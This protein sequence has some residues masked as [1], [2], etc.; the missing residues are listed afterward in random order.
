MLCLQ[1]FARRFC[2][3]VMLCGATA[4]A[5]QSLV[6]TEAEARSNA[7]DTEYRAT[8]RYVAR[9]PADSELEMTFRNLN[10]GAPKRRKPFSVTVSGKDVSE[11]ISWSEP[12]AVQVDYLALIDVGPP[13]NT[14][15][16]TKTV[17]DVIRQLALSDTKSKGPRWRFRFISG[18]DRECRLTDD[19]PAEALAS[20]PV[21]VL[22][23]EVAKARPGQ[24]PFPEEDMETLLPLF[25][26]KPSHVLVVIAE[27]PPLWFPREATEWLSRDDAAP[28]ERRFRG[29]ETQSHVRI[30]IP[31]AA[32]RLAEWISAGHVVPV[33]TSGRLDVPGETPHVSNLRAG[34]EEVFA[35][36][37]TARLQALLNPKHTLVEYRGILHVPL[38]H[39]QRPPSGVYDVQ[40]ALVANKERVTSREAPIAE[41]A[42]LSWL[43]RQMAFYSRV[44]LG[45]A[46]A[47]LVLLF[48][49]H[50]RRG[51]AH[52]D[53]EFARTA[54]NATFGFAAAAF[55]LATGLVGES[56][57]HYRVSTEAVIVGVA[58]TL[59]AFSL[60]LN[61]YLQAR[62]E[63][64]L[65]LE[66]V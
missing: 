42:S 38:M 51:V 25:E 15:I 20:N 61:R 17:T 36:V 53:S 28:A 44:I 43:P 5:P 27:T 57:L 12:E 31:S 32:A 11:H 41:R 55:G 13:G 64:E 58:L 59:I 46:L 29:F 63:T 22:E 34:T 54:R 9:V 35:R 49:S 37:K 7:D 23:A 56:Y 47:L 45:S 26:G 18:D 52:I 1:R 4:A 19:L 65:T 60:W 48:V 14:P 50:L 6:I 10:L 24:L 33:F 39:A 16:L 30:G 8:V 40:I 62:A 3:L 21:H 66:G 2:V